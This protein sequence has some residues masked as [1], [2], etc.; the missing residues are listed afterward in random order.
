M[1]KKAASFISFFLLTF[2]SFLFIS[3]FISEPVKRVKETKIEETSGNNFPQNYKIVSPKLPKKISFCGEP[4]PLKNIDV[5]E[6][7]DREIIVN[8]Y[9]H[10]LSI[11]SLKRAERW[12]P[13][14]EP[15]LKKYN[16]PDDLKYLA[17]SE[18]MLT[19]TISPAGATGF[20]QFK[21]ET[22]KEYGLEIN[23]EIDERYN[24]K[25]ATEAACK[26][27]TDSYERY[28]SWTLAAA[29]F[30]Y[31]R[32]A[33]ETQMKKQETNNYYNLVL[34]EETS[35]YVFRIIAIKEVMEHP[36]KYGFFLKKSDY[37][38]PYKTFTAKVNGS[39]KSWAEF[40]RSKGINYKILKMLNP[41]LRKSYLKNKHNKTYFVE[42]PQ[43]GSI[44]VIPERKI[45]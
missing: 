43:K 21:K 11:L 40:A 16:V 35:R 7:L 25:K 8:T 30:N 12:F 28:K 38:Q 17:L 1:L 22:A 19:N 37:Y 14:I 5:K 36:N 39:V 24:V 27:L 15:I 13:V 32:S 44:Y 33:L 18:S 29:S 41:W 34:P 6:R 10:S 42:L 31:G 2:V 4:V 26:F 45:D 3:S 23:K 20:W 9:W